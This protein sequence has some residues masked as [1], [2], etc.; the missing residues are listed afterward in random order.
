LPHEEAS[1]DYAECSKR[2]RAVLSTASSKTRH[3]GALRIRPVN[4]R[5][6]VNGENGEFGGL[7]E[8]HELKLR[9]PAKPIADSNLMAIRIPIHADHC[10]SEATLG[11][12]YHR[13][14]IGI[15]Q[16]ICI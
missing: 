15:R 7:R 9:I 12:F 4:K 11:C 2:W 5:G 14:L 13:E 8:A 3:N 6:P 1:Q 16:S 10:R